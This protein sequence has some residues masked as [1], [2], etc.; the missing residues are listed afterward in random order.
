MK[1][2][3]ITNS[4]GMTMDN[5]V[6][7]MSDQL[8]GV[9]S[10]DELS[11][12]E[13]KSRTFI[14]EIERMASKGYAISRIAGKVLFVPY[15][16][17]GDVVEIQIVKNK[18]KYMTAKPIRILKA[19]DGRTEPEC[20][21]YQTCGGCW[22][23]HADY[24]KE[25]EIKI[26][27]FKNTMSSIGKLEPQI[28][29]VIKSPSRTKYRNHIQIK[30]SIK[31]D[32]G[33]FMPEKIMVAPLPEQGCMLIP[34]EM[35][36]FVLELNRC[37]EKIKPHIN[38]RI[39]QNYKGEVFANGIIDHE[40]P[41]YFFEKVGNYTYRVGMHNFFQVN[42]YQIENWLNTILKY[43]GEGH[44]SIID[45]YCGVGLITLPLSQCS[46][47]VV[48]IE[49]NRKSIKDANYSKDLN[50]ITNVEFIDKDALIG[51][52]EVGN[53]DVVVVDPP[54]SGCK[55]EVLAEIIDREPKKIVYVSCDGA[56]FSRDSRILVDSGYELKEVQ[57]VDMFP[58][59]Y[60]LETIALFEKQ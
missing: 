44:K 43:V 15:V 19:G 50:N 24:D 30:S 20:P 7:D 2:F 51:M 3:Q 48:G 6:P 54:R 23:Q 9:D 45:L 17:I 57:P 40:A 18:S 49:M 56:T 22:F 10:I 38:F 35:N 33:F 12:E 14:I 58:F 53:A 59:T 25:L 29:E 41:E 60:H 26:E 47:K 32:L 27:A 36:E 21:I 4:E 8:G 5:L 1:Q 52:R 11:T 55:K 42:R 28:N 34:D 13:I 16:I 39:R 31:K 37:K 46:E